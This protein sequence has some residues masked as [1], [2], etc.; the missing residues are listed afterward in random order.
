MDKARTK[1]DLNL[2]TTAW[3]PQSNRW[4]LRATRHVCRTQERDNR[5]GCP[6][7]L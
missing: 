4:R 3:P 6:F 1:E 2:Q 7:L 5:F